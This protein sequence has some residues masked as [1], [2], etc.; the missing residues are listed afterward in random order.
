MELVHLRRVLWARGDACDLR[1]GAWDHPLLLPA[2]GARTQL[3]PNRGETRQ[4]DREDDKGAVK[5]PSS[6]S[7][8]SWTGWT[9]SIAEEVEGEAIEG[10]ENGLMKMHESQLLTPLDEERMYRWWGSDT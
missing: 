9:A 4:D 2:R 10:R 1:I 5:G 7:Y 3:D 6:I 8:I